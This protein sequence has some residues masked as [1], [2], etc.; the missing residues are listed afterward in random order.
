MTIAPGPLSGGRTQREIGAA[1]QFAPGLG[2]T[3]RLE[4]NLHA[5]LF[6]DTVEPVRTRNRFKRGTG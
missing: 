2:M 5:R 3:R 6:D 4:Q 1:R